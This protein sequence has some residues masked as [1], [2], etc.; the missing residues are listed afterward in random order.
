MLDYNRSMHP[1]FIKMYKREMLIMEEKNMN[2]LIAVYGMYA[3][4]YDKYINCYL[5][6]G[7]DENKCSYEINVCD[8]LFEKVT[9]EVIELT[10]SETAR[11]KILDILTVTNFETKKIRAQRNLFNLFEYI[12]MEFN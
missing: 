4:A 6:N 7:M 12:G 3:V 10:K 5:A 8:G 9:D 1:L 2:K 11:Q